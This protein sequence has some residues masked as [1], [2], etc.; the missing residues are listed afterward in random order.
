MAPGYNKSP[1]KLAGIPRIDVPLKKF[2]LL[3]LTE[4]GALPAASIFVGVWPRF[5]FS[6]A[7]GDAWMPS[8]IVT[9]YGT[10]SA[11]YLPG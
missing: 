7:K 4:P 9:F 10:A 5:S 11:P 3:A 1:I 2:L 8:A 6:K